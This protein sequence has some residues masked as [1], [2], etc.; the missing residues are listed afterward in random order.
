MRLRH[1]VLGWIFVLA[2][3]AL[4]QTLFE[5]DY[6]ERRSRTYD[7]FDYRL[8]LSFD[9]K[10]HTVAGTATITLGAICG[11]VD[12]VVL[13]A[14]AMDIGAVTRSDGHTLGFSYSG[15][16]L[17]V[18]LDPPCAPGD[19]AKV[20]VRYSCRPTKGL[21]FISADSTQ[22]GR[23]NEFW[24]QGEDM[25]NRYWFPCYDYPNDKATSEVIATVPAD[26]TL[27]SNGRLLGEKL[28]AGG[29]TRTFHWREGKVHSSYL[30][31]V[32]AGPYTI[33]RG[34]YRDIPLEYYMYA[35]DTAKAQATFGQTPA[36]LH[37]FEGVTGVPYPWEKFAQIVIDDFM[38]G[39]MEN[40]TAVTLNTTCV[41]DSR[42]ELDFPGAAVIAHELAH[43]W[44]GDLV[45]AR[46]WT[47]LWLNEGFA[48]YFENLYTEHA[49]GEDEF[50]YAMYRDR[51]QIVGEDRAS[52]R[53]PIVSHD[54]RPGD[55]YQRGAWVLHMLRGMLG[56]K[57]FY[58][59]LHAY[60][61][62]Y[63]YQCAETDELR[64]AFEDA[65]GQNL[66]YFFRE[67]VFKAGMP[68]LDLRKE[69]DADKGVLSVVVTQVQPLDSLTGIF[70]FP[71]NLECTTARGA[72][73]RSFWV[74]AQQETLRVALDGPP[75]MVIAD[76]GCHLLSQVE[77]P[78]SKEEYLYQLTHARDVVD[79]IG[80]VRGLA[81]FI[82]DEPVRE[83]LRQSARS[84]TF[85]A[86][87]RE[88]LQE[89]VKSEPA[90]ESAL[91]L[92]ASHD[93]KSS[94]RVAAARDLSRC[95]GAPY[96]ARL[97]E[98]ARTDSSYLVVS[99]ALRELAIADT[100]RAL[101]VAAVLIS[102]ESY[103]NL[104]RNGSLS[105][106][107]AIQSEQASRIALPYTAHG[108]T[109]DT[110]RLAA[111]VLGESGKSLPGSRRALQEMLKDADP[112]V[113]SSAVAALGSWDDAESIK[114]LES[115]R[116]H[117]SNAEV[118][119]A[120]RKALFSEENGKG[121]D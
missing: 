57:A 45:T 77:F 21:Y 115:L 10:E 66:D 42:A 14:V 26:Y 108:Y 91:L 116:T 43:M 109:S 75:L 36:M 2:Q 95:D 5:N 15:R 110:R 13:D 32:A 99:T 121:D 73:T 9:V 61:T 11:P 72:V 31:M 81:D 74:T 120:I 70:R 8:E 83:A 82:D 79:R 18:T 106:L 76:K 96:A 92:A 58:R 19:T 37:F 88:A 59:G 12:S 50:E 7:V 22:P 65:T 48:T 69:Y 62:K 102:Q 20:C 68:V 44:W 55:L 49:L 112:R 17:T 1:W 85:W 35:E 34:R 47:H 16:A 105:A 53:K 113:R 118:L 29:K 111:S 40:T 97:E 101:R 3:G 39:G 94:V 80:A 25:D 90:R 51:Q 71:L 56:D 104:I 30:I 98:M 119:A 87:R 6:N 38:W 54:P 103:R 60:L 33:L 100:G 107:R 46:D 114:Q 84:D 67:W 89:L 24:S 93:E 117:E 41:V 64:L 27:L 52:G 63:A 4:A 28:N 78:K 86:V 23:H